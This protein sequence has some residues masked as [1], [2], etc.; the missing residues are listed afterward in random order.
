MENRCANICQLIFQ[1]IVNSYLT[2]LYYG[3]NQ[4]RE[5]V[6]TILYGYRVM[7]K[8]N[9]GPQL[10]SEKVSPNDLVSSENIL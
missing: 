2:L 7:G 3:S 10:N 5:I 9:F 1:S 8:V 6:I 4:C